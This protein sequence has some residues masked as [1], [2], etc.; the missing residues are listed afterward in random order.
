M[1]RSIGC[2]QFRALPGG[3][4]KRGG[5]AVGKRLLHPVNHPF[6]FLGVQGTGAVD[7]PPAGAKHGPC[8]G[9][10]TL[11]PGR[12]SRRGLFRPF[13]AGLWVAAE[14]ALAAAGCVHQNR[15]EKSCPPGRELLRLGGNDQTVGHTHPF[16]IAA[17][18]LRPARHRLV[19][20]QQTPALQRIGDLGAL[21]P[22]GGAEIQH[23]LAGLGR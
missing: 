8:G 17:E 1:Q 12:A 21:S 4:G 13:G 16:Q 10:N 2:V 7:Q 22:R 14:H 15:I 23:P 9:Q 18:N 11:L 5:F 20:D 6:V 3:K 19:A